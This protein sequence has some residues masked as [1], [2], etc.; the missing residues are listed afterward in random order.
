MKIFI[1]LNLLIWSCLTQAQSWIDFSSKSA[2][3]PIL[4]Q[5]FVTNFGYLKNKII[6]EGKGSTVLFPV[7]GQNLIDGGSDIAWDEVRDSHNVW[8]EGGGYFTMPTGREGILSI[9]GSILITSSA[10]RFI[11]VYKGSSPAS[12]SHYK[13]C[14]NRNSNE[15]IISFNCK[16]YITGDEVFSL[17]INGGGASISVGAG[18]NIYHHILIH[19]E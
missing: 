8:T 11:S 7:S 4:L 12:L 6:F 19:E 18:N 17:R 5:D 13:N 1:I 14:S 3:D 16:I 15:D 2:G 10:I 9:S